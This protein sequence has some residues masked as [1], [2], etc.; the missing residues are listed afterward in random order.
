MKRQS[1]LDITIVDLK[2]NETL[3]TG[4]VRKPHLP[5]GE[6]VYLFLEF[7]IIRNESFIFSSCE[8]KVGATPDESGLGNLWLP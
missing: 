5:G 2:I 4:A 6:S 1:L 7:T 3:Q 8:K